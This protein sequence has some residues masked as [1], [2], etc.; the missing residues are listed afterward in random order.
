ML[1]VVG[2]F[3]DLLSLVCCRCCLSVGRTWSERWSS[4]RA[5]SHPWSTDSGTCVPTES[6]PPSWWSSLPTRSDLGVTMWPLL[7]SNHDNLHTPR[8]WGSVIDV[9]LILY[10]SGLDE[11]KDQATAGELLP[12]GFRRHWCF[13]CRLDN[14]WRCSHQWYFFSNRL[15]CLMFD[16]QTCIIV[17][18]L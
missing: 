1:S 15:I 3:I 13:H 18:N 7:G 4:S 2:L 10:P 12:V 14:E 6:P 11:R 8:I 16:F 9:Y 17:N 5:V